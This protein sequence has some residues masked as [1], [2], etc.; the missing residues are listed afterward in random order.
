VDL[1]AASNVAKRFATL[2]PLSCFLLLVGR[3]LRPAAKLHSARLSTFPAFACAH[4]DKVA[5]ELRKPA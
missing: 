5:L 3:E 2:L 1:V 4:L